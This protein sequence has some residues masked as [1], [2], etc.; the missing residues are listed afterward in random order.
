MCWEHESRSAVSEGED[1]GK[2]KT[3]IV[4]IE[5][6]WRSFLNRQLDQISQGQR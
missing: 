2:Y 4:F 1:K 3:S 5:S 6:F